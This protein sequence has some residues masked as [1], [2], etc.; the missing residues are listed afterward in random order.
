[1]TAS[2]HRKDAQ[3]RRM[4][5]VRHL[6]NGPA[7]SDNSNG[8]LIGPQQGLLDKT[9][10]RHS[11]RF[12]GQ[13]SGDCLRRLAIMTNMCN[14]ILFGTRIAFNVE[15]RANN[16]MVVLRGSVRRA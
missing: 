6:K 13:V 14:A 15:T 3:S 10:L 2:T 5:V 11:L 16:P 12:F 8:V 4:D 1:M 9:K 7:Q